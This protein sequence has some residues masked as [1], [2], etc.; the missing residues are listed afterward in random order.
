MAVFMDSYKTLEEK[1]RWKLR[2]DATCYFKQFLETAT[3]KTTIVLLLAAY[4][5]THPNKTNKALLMK[6]SDGFPQ[7]DT[8]VLADQQRLA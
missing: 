8:P 7:T 5:K 3:Y 2:K 4:L 1:A 6:F